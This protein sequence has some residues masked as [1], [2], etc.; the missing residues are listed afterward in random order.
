MNLRQKGD[1]FK[2]SGEALSSNSR[3]DEK[4]SQAVSGDLYHFILST[5]L[6][7]LLG[8]AIVWLASL[9]YSLA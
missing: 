5:F 6:P 9:Q 1:I 2:L 7:F 8:V 3:K 4:L